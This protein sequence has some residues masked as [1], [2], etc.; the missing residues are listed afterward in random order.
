MKAYSKGMPMFRSALGK[1]IGQVGAQ[2]ALPALVFLAIVLGPASLFGQGMPASRAR[3]LEFPATLRQEVTAGKTSIGTKVQAKLTVATLVNGVVVP[4]DA[5]LSGEVVESAAKTS[6][7][8]SR[9][10]IRMDSIQWKNGTTE[11]KA[12][13]T[14][15]FYPVQLPSTDTSSDDPFDPAHRPHNPIYSGSPT[16]PFPA[17]SHDKE[18][19]PPPGASDSQKSPSR[20]ALKNVQSAYKDDGAVALTSAQINIK[21]DKHTTYVFAA[22]DAPATK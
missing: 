2:R 1:A 7:E 20:V 15:W 10:A 8:P 17:P 21:L 9:L 22:G 19:V 14:A 12:Y 18:T 11:I 5:V 3:A 6:T 16:P 13:L 4:R